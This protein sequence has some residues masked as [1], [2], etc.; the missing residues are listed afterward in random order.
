MITPN[1]HNIRFEL[2]P[3]GF[4]ILTQANKHKEFKEYISKYSSGSY[5]IV[6]EIQDVDGNPTEPHYHVWIE[7]LKVKVPTFS[8]AIKKQWDNLL[9]RK[10][11]G[12][13]NNF[14]A[15]IRFLNDKCQ[16]YYLFKNYETSLFTSN[17]LL[18]NKIKKTYKDIY[19]KICET[20]K[21]GASGEFYAYVCSEKPHLIKKISLIENSSGDPSALISVYIDWCTEKDKKRINF[22][23]CQNHINYI[24]A[25]ENPHYLINSWKAKLFPK[26][27]Y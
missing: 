15:G 1:R 14:P 26:Y 11:G 10:G 16:F 5:V 7:H 18:N 24:L 4:K 8:D 25:R 13:D 2:S 19:L 6:E 17:M 3:K 23:D 20:K 27:N 12:G 9:K 21:L 22:N